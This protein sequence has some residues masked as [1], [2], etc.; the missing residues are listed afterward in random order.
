MVLITISSTEI[1]EIVK[2]YLLSPFGSA[3]HVEGEPYRLPSLSC[4]L[5]FVVL[6]AVTMKCLCLPYILPLVHTSGLCGFILYFTLGN[7]GVGNRCGG[8]TLMM[9]TTTHAG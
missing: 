7:V 6:M 4:G 3:W 8:D 5:R 9:V 2:L 1:K